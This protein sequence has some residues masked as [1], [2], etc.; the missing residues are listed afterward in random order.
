V[1]LFAR[2]LIGLAIGADSAIA[3]AC[4]VRA[5]EPARV[6]LSSGRSPSASWSLPRRADHLQRLPG[7]HIQHRLA[8]GALPNDLN[9]AIP[10]LI[11]LGRVPRCSTQ[12]TYGRH[13]LYTYVAD[14]GPGQTNG[15]NLNL[16]GGLWREVT[17]TR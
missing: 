4:R 2:T 1:R 10:A 11:G 5:Q 9:G 8:D 17:M 12:A 7:Q 6:M 13:P 15:N 16:N 3:T 14:S